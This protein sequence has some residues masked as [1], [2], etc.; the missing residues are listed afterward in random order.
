MAGTVRLRDGVEIEL[1][2]G[3]VVVCDATSPDGDVAVV[4]HAH[5]DHL[6]SAAPD[7]A[8][9]SPLTRDLAAVRRPDDDAPALQNHPRIDLHDAGHIPGSRAALVEGER[10]YL[11]TGDVC[12]RDRLTLTGFDPP[13]ADV[14]I[15]ESTYGEPAYVF[16][17]LAEERAAFEDWLARNAAVPVV[18]FGYALGRAQEIQH[19]LADSGRD[20]VF[21]SEAIA[22]L[23][24]VIER[25]TAATFESQTWSADVDL[26]AGDALVMP[27]GTSSF[28]WAEDLVAE[29][30]AKTAGLSGWA[31]DSS[32]KFANGFDETFVLSDHCDFEEL[33]ALVR[34]VDPEEVYTLHGSARAFARHLTSAEG[35]EATALE[36]NQTSLSEF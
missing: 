16:P 19:L 15:V 6:Y 22:E 17:P 26:G 34:A 32:Y 30:D 3:E 35:Y 8:V 9:M 25:H 12:T 11:Y 5:G 18:V 7:R 2:S 27:S 4:S 36:R 1:E 29:T 21:V 31:V 28:T 24:A 13:S 20:R 10:T 33:V 14:L 23:N